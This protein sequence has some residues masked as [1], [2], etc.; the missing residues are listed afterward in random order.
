MKLAAIIACGAASLALGHGED[1]DYGLAIMDGSVAVGL[2]DHD[3]GTITEFGERVFAAEMA[4]S[5][6]NWFADEP[7]IF[8]AEGSLLDNT[9]VSFTLTSALLYWD[10]TEAVD[11]S[12][13][14]N[15]MTLSFG[16][17]SVS[18]AFD[19][20]PVAGF[21]INYDADQV[22]GFDEHFDYTIDASAGA[23]IYVLANTFSL[24]GA[25]DSEVIFTVFNAGLEEDLHEEAIE[26]VEHVLVPAP[27][28]TGVL[29]IAGLGVMSRRRRS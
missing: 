12:Q 24:T 13:S 23:G 29:A 6:S 28:A 16:P 10:G 26:Y 25:A 8:I 17:A 5:G 9:Q 22:G 20:N 27:G 21:S 1:A 14:A 3:T 4:I 15:A 18:T 7:G 2:G 11:F 19:N